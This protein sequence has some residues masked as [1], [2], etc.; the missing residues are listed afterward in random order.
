MVVLRGVFVL[1]LGNACLLVD[2]VGLHL[3][4]ILQLL[5]ANEAE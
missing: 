1:L 5:H 4:D 3:D 2:L